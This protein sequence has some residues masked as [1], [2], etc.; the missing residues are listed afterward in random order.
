MALLCTFANLWIPVFAVAANSQ[1]PD[2]ETQEAE[3][4]LVPFRP[5]A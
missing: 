4:D 5:E 3:R 1:A 2:G